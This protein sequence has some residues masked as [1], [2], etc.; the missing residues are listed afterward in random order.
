[1]CHRGRFYH[2]GDFGYNDAIRRKKSNV[3][4]IHH[5]FIRPLMR[6]AIKRLTKTVSLASLYQNSL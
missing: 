4:D 3:G 1:M 6:M 2:H 5:R